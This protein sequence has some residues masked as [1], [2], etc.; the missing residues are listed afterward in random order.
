MFLT[1]YKKCAILFESGVV[2]NLAQF[3]QPLVPYSFRFIGHIF[4]RS[5]V[6]LSLEYLNNVRNL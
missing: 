5:L 6:L 2:K 3:E 4:G 1:F